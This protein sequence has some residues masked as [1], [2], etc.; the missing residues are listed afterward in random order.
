MTLTWNSLWKTTVVGGA[1]AVTGLCHPVWAQVLPDGSLGAGRS[2]V[3]G[4]PTKDLIQG[5][6][7]RGANLFHSFSEFNVGL[8][9]SVYFA[10][11][12]GIGNILARVTGGNG[13][14]LL[15]R[16]GVEGSA[17]LFLLNPK[18]I[19]FG[20]GA[21]LD[22]RGSFV[23]STAAGL[24]FSNGEVFSAIGPT[25]VPLVTM[26][27]PIGLQVG[28]V[29][30]GNLE[31]NGNLSVDAGKALTLFGKDV[32][33]RGSLVAPGGTV[34]VLGDR[35]RLVDQARV[36]VSA[37]M[38]SGNIRIGGGWQG[39]EGLPRSQQTIVGKDVVLRSD[40][41]NLGNAGKIAVWS[42]G[43]T[44]F[45]GTAIARGGSLGG[46]GG[47][48]EVSGARSIVYEGS[49]DARAVQGR[50]GSL[51]LDP[52]NI[53]VVGF[54]GTAIADLTQVDQFNDANLAPNLTQ[55]RA[56]VINAAT[57]DVTLQASQ[58]ITVNGD[59]NLATQGVG[60]KLQAGNNIVLNNGIATNAGAIQLIAGDP[61]SGTVGGPGN[62]TFNAQ[63]SSSGGDVI[64]RATGDITASGRGNG[65]NTKSQFALRNS[66]NLSIVTPGT[67]TIENN[68]RFTTETSSSANGGDI[69]IN[70]GKIDLI[71]GRSFLF[72]P[73]NTGIFSDGTGVATGK[74]GNITIETQ[75][76]SVLS[77]AT[78]TSGQD[79]TLNPGQINIKSG[80]VDVSGRDPSR[81]GNQNSQISAI[82]KASNISRQ[83]QGE[84]TIIADRLS[85]TNTGY[86]STSLGSDNQSVDGSIGG[87]INL[88]VNQIYADKGYIISN[89][90]IYPG[91]TIKLNGGTIVI[92]SKD[93]LLKNNSSINT[94]S[95]TGESG[96]IYIKSE[97]I[98]LDQKGRI[99]AEALQTI[100]IIGGGFQSYPNNTSGNGGIVDISVN[101]LNLNNQS[102]ISAKSDFNN[103]G[104]VRINANN[105]NVQNQS[106]I[107]ATGNNQGGNIQVNVAG[108]FNLNQ[109]SEI[110]SSAG[111]KA[112]NIQVNAGNIDIKNNSLV[113]T[114]GIN[115]GGNIDINTIN[116]LNLNQRSSIITASTKGA[117]GNIN[118]AQNNLVIDS[119]SSVISGSLGRG[120]GG[121]IGV[122]SRDTTTI[123]KNLSKI[124]SLSLGESSG[125]IDV[126]TGTLNIFDTG[127]INTTSFGGNGGNMTI[128]ATDSINLNNT[129]YISTS[130]FSNRGN[131]GNLKIETPKLIADNFSNISTS[132]NDP[133]LLTPDGIKRISALYKFDETKIKALENIAAFLGPLASPSGSVAK[134]GKGGDLEVRADYISLQRVSS[135]Q[136]GSFGKNTGGNLNVVT[137]DISIENSS[138]ISADVYGSGIAGNLTLSAGKIFLNADGRIFAS[139]QSGNGGNIIITDN[140]QLLMRRQSTITT[141]SGS[142]GSPGNAG[143]IT[144]NSAFI[145]APEVENNDIFANAYLGKGGTVS[146]LSNRVIGF[147]ILS[148][149]DLIRILA[150][151]DP[152][153]LDPYYISTNNI[154]AAAI[155][156][157]A[158][159]GTIKVD[160]LKI[161]P[162][163]G[164]SAPPIGPRKPD[165]SEDCGNQNES[166][167]SRIVNSGRGGLTPLPNDALTSQTLW[168]DSMSKPTPLSIQPSS[169]DESSGLRI[170]NHWQRQD[171]RTVVLVGNRNTPV[172]RSTL[173]Y[174]QR[175]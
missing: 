95:V 73:S 140:E 23:A 133:E 38:G 111:G 147:S 51:L 108:N 175:E 160:D 105:I 26:A 96:K 125:N 68:A 126:L 87:L 46:D 90:L 13:S 159:N 107:R 97:N 113:Q 165:V 86:L 131:S 42:D 128:K 135:I 24:T 155:S 6:V 154:I 33:V 148:R 100:D 30:L 122:R 57:A 88:K 37:P 77:G 40:A 130:T 80:T 56:A 127:S 41:R 145:I 28:T 144:I 167:G 59:I 60:I 158:N 138:A 47:A 91:I 171:D 139:S 10:N 150:T 50:S 137:K 103:A 5:G 25:D 114:I 134:I 49:V 65:V 162:S 20:N 123:S 54:F 151:N 142:V 9:R 120:V 4:G 172:S 36:D 22:V 169:T 17:N 45:L 163:R 166:Q 58:N 102:F 44:R 2:Q 72:L 121:N 124:Q 12:A 71:G 3:V 104:T 119:G 79:F 64:L 34:Q 55:I 1:I 92:D 62:I 43:E 29:G 132:Y 82:M 89:F 16:L 70:A 157:P 164:L 7:S 85:L 19:V 76:L 83:S 161:D 52:T 112:G 146:I 67:L 136:S 39:G 53:E 11:P 129:T 48:V 99:H 21:S 14:L 152:A 35:V 93:I 69:N 170:A 153:N 61:T 8:G 110:T 143:N 106:L 156:N 174:L 66:G 98:T 141:K 84:I 74:S 149:D 168:S 15:G 109:N 32:T 27:V 78:L 94:A 18:G 173:C 116:N 117:A 63:A 31:Q 101:S 115:Q 118:L 75:S 81:L